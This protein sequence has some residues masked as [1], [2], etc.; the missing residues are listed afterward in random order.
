VLASG[1]TYE[2]EGIEKWLESHMT[3]PKT[4]SILDH[5]LLTPNLQ[6][7]TL[8]KD[9]MEKNKIIESDINIANMI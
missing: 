6:L 2:R 1:H 3:D 5:T 9:W 7:K 4:G 8:I